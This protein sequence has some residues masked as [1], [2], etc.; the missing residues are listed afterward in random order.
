MK[1]INHKPSIV[2]GRTLGILGVFACVLSA[3]V[4]QAGTKCYDFSKPEVGTTYSIGQT[5]D[6]KHSTI[7]VRRLVNKD[8]PASNDTAVAEI[9][10]GNL[11]QGGAPSLRMNSIVAQVV[12][13]KLVKKMTLKFA[14]N[15][16]SDPSKRL[17]NF[18]VNGDRRAF[19]GSLEQ[20]NGKVLGKADQ[21]GKVKVSVSATPDGGDSFWV[22]G[23]VTLTPTKGLP[24][25]MKGIKKFSFGASSQLFIDDVCIEEK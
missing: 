7:N 16:G 4:V 18:G 5:L 6:L 24:L 3:S 13:N 12:P 2:L 9:H 23:T 10:A 8:G 11:P 19:N 15:L 14:Q 22:R 21:G 25:P 20:M 1:A 17:V